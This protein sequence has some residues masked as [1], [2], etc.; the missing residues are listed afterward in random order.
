MRNLFIY[1]FLII[2]LSLNGC[3]EDDF[4]SIAYP[5]EGYPIEFEFIFQSSGFSY[6]N[7]VSTRDLEESKN[8]FEMED[9]IHILGEFKDTKGNTIKKYGAMKFVNGKFEAIPGSD[10]TWPNEE[11]TGVFK[12]FYISNSNSLIED[13]AS[14]EYVSLSSLKE[15]TDPLE[16]I[17]DEYKWGHAVKLQF[18]HSC[19]YLKLKNL[20]PGVTSYFKLKTSQPIPNRFQLSRQDNDLKILF[21]NSG[22]NYISRPVNTVLDDGEVT[23]ETEYFLAPG[24]YS[25]FELITLNNESYLS[26]NNEELDNL[27]ANVP[28]I[29]DVK[30]SKGV[31]F[32]IPEEEVWDT[33]GEFY[34]I[35]VEKFIKA[36]VESNSYTEQDENGNDVE[37]LQKTENGTLLVKNVD[38]QFYDEYE[39]FD[40]EPTIRS[41]VIFDG[42]RHTIMNIGYPLFRHNQGTIQNL[43]LETI[44]SEVILEYHNEET[45][46]GNVKDASRQ[47]G[48]C[49]RNRI[50]AT[51]QNL[52]VKNVEMNLTVI[53]ANSQETHNAGGLVGQNEGTIVNVN[54]SGE[55]NV[56]VSNNDNATNINAT[57]NIGGIIGQNNG[58]ISNVTPLDT[59]EELSINVLNQCQGEYGAFYVGGG[60]GFNSATMDHLTIQ[61]VDVDNS[62]CAGNVLY[63]GGLAGRMSST[64]ANSGNSF[65]LS[66]TVSGSVKG[67]N[68]TN[69]LTNSS[70]FTG[71]IAGGI[72]YF[73]V[74]DCRSICDVEGIENTEASTE[75][76]YGTGGAFGRILNKIAVENITAYGSTLKGPQNYIGN[77]AGIIPAGETYDKDYQN[78]N[79]IIK[80]HNY[81]M[82]GDSQTPNQD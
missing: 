40:F 14:T 56:T 51:I 24:N 53:S 78:G 37:I 26:F 59:Q 39:S 49:C 69:K 55:H 52:R 42:G 64:E 44:K 45:E 63:T 13:G 22:N 10:L 21:S 7:E 48:V 32:T 15:D 67:G 72:N 23:A 29:L 8:K 12:A 4:S 36:V 31:T 79:M 43:A 60:V 46:T 50:G 28:Y 1:I 38:F 2:S 18:T 3:R 76:L 54:I 27:Y 6:D 30:K 19:T 17:S 66:S 73:T 77:F 70:S 57:I 80:N 25:N 81:P 5:K 71:G 35:D 34:E 74:N 20:D 11:V 82:V 75:V 16:A 65:L 33:S 9:V 68:S 58:T 61:N 41:G 47:G 62:K